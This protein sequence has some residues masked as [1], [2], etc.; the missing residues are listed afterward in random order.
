MAVEVSVQRY[1]FMDGENI[2]KQYIDAPTDSSVSHCKSEQDN[3]R[4]DV[5]SANYIH[6]LESIWWILIWVLLGYRKA[7]SEES[8]EDYK[9]E[10]SQRKKI[11]PNYSA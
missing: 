3:N 6:D 5:F 11:L 10:I 4:P 7:G 9:S 8:T 1:L 2:A